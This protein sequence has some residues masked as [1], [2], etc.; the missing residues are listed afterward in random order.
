MRQILEIPTDQAWSSAAFAFWQGTGDSRTAVDLSDA[1]AW[2]RDIAG[3]VLEL[4]VD[5]GGIAIAD[6]AA[7]PSVEAAAL[8]S[9]APGAGEFEVQVT[10]AASGAVRQIRAPVMLKPG[11]AR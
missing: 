11:A 3:V 10:L 6:N 4:T 1:H 9:L 7:T 5:N 8:Q 2:L